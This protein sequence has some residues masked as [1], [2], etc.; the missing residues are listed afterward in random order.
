MQRFSFCLSSS[1]LVVFT[2]LSAP[3]VRLVSFRV[4]L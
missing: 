4:P 2:A 3:F 1:L